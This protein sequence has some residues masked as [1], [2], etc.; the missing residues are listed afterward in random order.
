[1]LVLTR[2]ANERVII[3]ELIEVCVLETHGN[4]VKLGFTGP[5]EV[6]IHREEVYRRLAAEKKG[7]PPC[8]T[9]A[10]QDCEAVQP[11]A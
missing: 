3:G 2:K 8:L 9:S 5:K 10:L 6:P 11:T 4:M 7:T 1:M